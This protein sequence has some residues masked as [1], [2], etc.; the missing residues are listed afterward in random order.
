MFDNTWTRFDERHD[1]N[2][3]SDESPIFLLAAGWR[4][5]STLLQRIIASSGEVLMWG[6]PYGRASIIPGLTRSAMALRPERPEEGYAGW[7]HSGHFAPH[8]LADK[9]EDH[10]IANHFPPAQAF[11]QG[12]QAH[13]DALFS[14]P[15]KAQGAARWGLKEVRLH[16]MD[17][18]FLNWVYPKA[19]FVFLLR[20]PWDAWASAKGATWWLRWPDRKVETAPE[21]AHHW[22]RL[23]QSFL[24]WPADNGLLVRYEDLVRDSFDLAQISDHCGLTQVQ[25]VRS[26]VI[27]GMARP[28]SA[29]S[30][31]EV[32]QIDRVCGE[33]ARACCYDGPT[34]AVEDAPSFA[35]V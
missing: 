5:G 20:N 3:G 30:S 22:R 16:G 24:E 21:F 35:T 18:Q 32:A 29:L 26:E 13:L 28:P 9:P 6:E 34:G 33:L 7:P 12:F 10:W 19:R 31:F 27:R 8:Q 25:D 17:G 15:A 2:A 23:A 1:L 11:K 4:S 14:E